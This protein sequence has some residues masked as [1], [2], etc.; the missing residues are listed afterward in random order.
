MTARF[1]P[2]A[3]CLAWVFPAAAPAQLPADLR[4][5]SAAM[6]RVF[7]TGI[8]GGNLLFKPDRLLPG[9]VAV[10]LEQIASLD[11]EIPENLVAAAALRR[12]GR[13]HEALAVYDKTAAPYLRFAVVETSNILPLFL[14]VADTRRVTGSP[15]AAAD[16]VQEYFPDSDAMPDAVRVILAASMLDAGNASG[17]RTVI[18][19][20]EDLGTGDPCFL[21]QQA[22]MAR[23]AAWDG[24]PVSAADLAARGLALG[25]AN[26]PHYPELLA[27]AAD[28]YGALAKASTDGAQTR[29]A[30][31]QR[32]ILE[33]LTRFYPD[34]KRLTGGPPP[35]GQT[36][37]SQP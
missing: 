18:A 15:Q 11:F 31:G 34:Y 32:Q 17:A 9:T 8:R 12:T 13:A 16:F 22:V 25:S 24:D 4:G 29:A 36:Q 26:A 27:V 19:A 23:L 37:P 3:L 2:P 1:L 21:L 30:E 20:A 14:D 28:I 33:Q 35:T 6:G 7:V 5:E 10:P